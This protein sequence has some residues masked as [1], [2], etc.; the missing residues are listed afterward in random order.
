MD[1]WAIRFRYI[2]PEDYHTPYMYLPIQEMGIRAETADEA[3][4]KLVTGEHAGPRDNYKKIE[5]YK[6]D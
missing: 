5:I 2:A 3:W 4:E 6:A 1:L